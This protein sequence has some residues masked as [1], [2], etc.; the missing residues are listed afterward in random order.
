MYPGG[1]EHEDGG[2]RVGEE[3][4]QELTC[5][6]GKWS[7]FPREAGDRCTAGKTWA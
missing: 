4:V 2:N 6:T 7:Q 3:S 5:A 1:M